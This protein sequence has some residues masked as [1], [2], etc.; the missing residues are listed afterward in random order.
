MPSASSG[1]TSVRTHQLDIGLLQKFTL[2]PKLTAPAQAGQG[3]QLQVELKREKT[4]PR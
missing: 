2:Y 3:G 1:E 4:K